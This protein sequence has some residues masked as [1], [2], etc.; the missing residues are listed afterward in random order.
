MMASQNSSIGC[1][2]SSYRPVAPQTFSSNT[3]LHR[4]AIVQCLCVLEVIREVLG[5]KVFS[6]FCADGVLGV[7]WCRSL[8]VLF[9]VLLV[10]SGI[11]TY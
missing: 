10:V 11:V 7:L 8:P 3:I 1:F 4:H 6:Q 9:L 2:L 5:V